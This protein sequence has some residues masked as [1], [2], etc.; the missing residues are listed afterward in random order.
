MFSFQRPEHITVR[1]YGRTSLFRKHQ[2]RDLREYCSELPANSVLNLGAKPDDTDKEGGTYED[3][4]AH[5]KFYTLDLGSN[6]HPRHIHADLMNLPEGMSTYDVVLV[7]SV[8]EHIDRPWKASPQIESLIKPGGYLYIAMP[9]FYPVHEGP[10][11]GDHWRATPSAMKF[12]F[13]N[14]IEIRHDIYPSSIRSVRDRK[15]YWNK[16]NACAA[17]FSMLMRK[18]N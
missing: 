6:E 8:I 17:G 3:Y 10:Y 2:N 9:F 16:P 1:R 11:Y 14:L 18:P 5:A 12:L 7:M 13:E 4:F 15:T